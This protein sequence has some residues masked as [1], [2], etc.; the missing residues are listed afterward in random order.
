MKVHINSMDGQHQYSDG[1]PITDWHSKKCAWIIRPEFEDQEINFWG[2]D[3]DY[4]GAYTLKE[5]EDS[6]PNWDKLPSISVTWYWNT[7][8]ACIK[9]FGQPSSFLKRDDR[10][11][12]DYWDI[13]HYPY[14]HHK[15]WGYIECVEDEAVERFGKYCSFNQYADRVRVTYN[16]KVIHDGILT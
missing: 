6:H 8:E 10:H 2:K 7:K 16:D 12:L 9:A 13:Q 11:I 5:F 14:I 1:V 4:P 15:S 3:N